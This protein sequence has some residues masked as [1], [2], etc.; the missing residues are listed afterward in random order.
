MVKPTG[1]VVSDDPRDAVA[2]WFARLSRYCADVDY[3]SART[4]FADDVVSFGTKA[5]IVAGLGRLAAEQWQG[6]WPNIT[7]FR[8]DLDTVRSGGAGD[9]A[10]GVA[11]WTSTGY[12]EQH[13]PFHRPG[14]ATVVLERRGDGDDRAWLCVH[15]HFSLNPGTPQKTFGKR[16]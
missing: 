9:L 11:V 1:P 13:R 4:I 3:A 14:R 16:R 5:E 7:D 2:Q 8:I 10:W 15:S 6:I 12:D